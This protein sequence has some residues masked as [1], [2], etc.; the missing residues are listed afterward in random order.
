M[1][2]GELLATA[3]SKSGRIPVL[4]PKCGEPQWDACSVRIQRNFPSFEMVYRC[5]TISISLDIRH[6]TLEKCLYNCIRVGEI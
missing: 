1:I 5:E 2:L 4:S 6:L 3:V